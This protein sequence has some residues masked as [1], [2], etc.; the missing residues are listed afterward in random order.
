ML[1]LLQPDFNLKKILHT[2][3]E[4]VY[5]LYTMCLSIVSNLD[6]DIRLILYV[7]FLLYANIYWI[8]LYSKLT[9]WS[10]HSPCFTHSRKKS[11]SLRIPGVLRNKLL[12]LYHIIYLFPTLWKQMRIRQCHNLYSLYKSRS[13]QIHFLYHYAAIEW[14]LTKHTKISMV[15]F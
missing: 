7:C 1:Y 14:I 5:W 15:I 6:V 10:A 13:S 3:L 12:I 11:S 9:M 2:Y 8:Q 4:N